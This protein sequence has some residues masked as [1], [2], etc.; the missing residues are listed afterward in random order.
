MEFF[1]SF[2]E[3]FIFL[4]TMIKIPKL[5]LIY[6]LLIYDLYFF[7][8]CLLAISILKEAY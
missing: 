2:W 5:M 7:D 4:L 8:I 6:I 1:F 3:S